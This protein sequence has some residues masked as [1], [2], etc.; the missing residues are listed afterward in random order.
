MVARWDD[1]LDLFLVTPEEFEKLPDGFELT[2]IFGNKYIKG[3]DNI[4]FDTR[5][6]HMAFG[7]TLA[8][9]EKYLGEENEKT[10]RD[11]VGSTSQ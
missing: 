2:C 6:G 5:F 10:Q 3:K 11:G 1:N 8:E 9:L 7:S 4:D